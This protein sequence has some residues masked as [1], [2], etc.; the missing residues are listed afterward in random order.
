MLN[1]DNS[2]SGQ[3]VI[4]FPKRRHARASAGS[5]AASLAKVSAVTPAD[6]AGSDCE[7]AN[8]HS[9]GMRSLCDHF[10]M[11]GTPAP[12][13]DAIASCDGQSRITSRNE[14]G[15]CMPNVLGQSVLKSKPNVSHDDCGPMGQNVPMKNQAKS[16]YKAAFLGRVA[17]ARLL[18]F[19]TQDPAATAIGLAQDTYKQYETRSLMPHHL[20]PRFCAICGVSTEW[21]ISG[22]GAGPAVMPAPEVKPRAPKRAARRTRVA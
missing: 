2:T 3:N 10:R 4:A 14:A 20:I 5:R 16:A 22:K 17:A 13:S 21:L 12:R 8:H 6:F 9:P 19:E 18:R 15:S 1:E 7:T 11:A